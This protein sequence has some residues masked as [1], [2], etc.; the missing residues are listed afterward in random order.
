MPW[1]H[2]LAVVCVG[3]SKD[4]P[5]GAE[6]G[7]GTD[8][9]AQASP[10]RL[11]CQPRSPLRG[12]PASRSRAGGSQDRPAQPSSQGQCPRVVLQTP[13]RMAPRPPGLPRPCGC[14]WS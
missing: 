8:Q 10:P 3:V 9:G 4:G 13:P 11:P 1:R 7:P 2:L 14:A 12:A 6:P 5:G